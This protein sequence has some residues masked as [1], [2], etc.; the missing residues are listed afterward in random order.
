MAIAT[1]QLVHTS[2]MT[3]HS[4]CAAAMGIVTHVPD[5]I[6]PDA[7]CGICSAEYNPWSDRVAREF[8][9]RERC[10]VGKR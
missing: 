3:V 10:C 2:R 7:A 8:G 6:D 9:H 5:R 4:G 1:E